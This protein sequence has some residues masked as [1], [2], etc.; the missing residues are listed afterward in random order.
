MSLKS[1]SGKDTRSVIRSSN[2]V[3]RSTVSGAWRISTPPLPGFVEVRG[4]MKA[5]I[6]NMKA[7][8]YG[9][10]QC[11]LLTER[12]EGLLSVARDFDDSRHPE[13]AD[14]ARQLYAV[15]EKLKAESRR[16]RQSGVAGA[17][18]RENMLGHLTHKI[19]GIVEAT[20]LRIQLRE[21][22]KRPDPFDNFLVVGAHEITEQT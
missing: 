2:T 14:M 12:I 8:D 5:L 21:A 19:D 15:K 17:E 6:G 10:E 7:Q 4:A 22:E 18:R 3:I 13:L 9:N 1:A 20:S 11:A 16:Q